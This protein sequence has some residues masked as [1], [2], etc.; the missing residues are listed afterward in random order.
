MFFFYVFK[1][2]SHVNVCSLF[3]PFR[4]FFNLSRTDVLSITYWIY[5]CINLQIKD[6]HSIPPKLHWHT[7]LVCFTA[8]PKHWCLHIT[9]VHCFLLMQLSAPCWWSWD[10]AVQ[11]TPTHAPA[12]TC[13]PADTT[14]NNCGILKSFKDF[15]FFFFFFK[16]NSITF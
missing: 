15:S 10:S 14:I 3:F 13:S 11:C 1:Q 12:Y 7:L 16:K 6:L 5:L 9:V 2:N 8:V 4:A